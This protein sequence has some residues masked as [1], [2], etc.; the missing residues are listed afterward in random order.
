MKPPG[1]RSP[2][3]PGG[4]APGRRASRV[5]RLR[6]LLDAQQHELVR[7][8]VEPL[9]RI[10]PRDPDLIALA[11]KAN[12]GLSRYAQALAVCARAAASGMND[13]L[14]FLR[15]EAFRGLSRT[16]EALADFALAARMN[17]QMLDARLS[18]VAALEEAGRTAESRAALDAA[19]A[20]LKSA[21]KPP[22]PKCNFEHAKLLIH[23]RKFTEAIAAIDDL[24]RVI[25]R[26]FKQRR[27]TLHLRVKACDRAGDYSG[28]W[29]TA[30]LALAEERGTFDPAAYSRATDA[31]I[32]YWTRERLRN[33]ARSQELDPTPVFI[34][35]MPRSGTTLLEQ[36][37]AAHPLG[38]GV[39]EFHI[40]EPFA[41]EADAALVFADPASGAG[42]AF[43]E[44]RYSQMA[45]EYLAEIRARHPGAS[46]IANKSLLND[47]MAGHLSLLF[48]STRIVHIQRDPRDVAISCVLGG[49]DMTRKPWTSRPEWAAH[50]WSESERLMQHWKSV[51]DAPVL[52]LKYEDLVHAGAPALR[53]VIEFVGLP[54]DEAVTSFHAVRRTVRTLSYDQVNQPLYTTAVGRWKNYEAQLAGMAWPAYR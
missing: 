5:Q 1:D 45:R 53:S 4:A 11:A 13:E 27:M 50:A 33:A 15:G 31:M 34:A 14:V 20:V 29:E 21:G 36:I 32:A 30:Q 3:A 18:A 42:R 7:A 38:E 9:L 2:K 35:G 26:G 46:R 22:T 37:I 16:D 23:E 44:R 48:P 41:A 8:E 24:L 6:G 25:P 40:I 19:V 39:G 17:P 12:L 43:G 52:H 49:F 54:W 10:D 47:R 51:L 28:A